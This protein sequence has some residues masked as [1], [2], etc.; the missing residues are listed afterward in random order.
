MWCVGAAGSVCLGA[1]GCLCERCDVPFVSVVS[2]SNAD[3]SPVMVLIP[4]AISPLNV[5]SRPTGE[6]YTSQDRFSKDRLCTLTAQTRISAPGASRPTNTG[7]H[8]ALSPGCT[9]PELHP[10]RSARG[11]LESTQL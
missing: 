8:C 5:S 6:E 4:T 1:C 9:T 2:G 3:C 11:V 10:P 7:P